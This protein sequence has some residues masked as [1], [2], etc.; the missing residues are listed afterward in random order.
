[1]P[2]GQRKKQDKATFSEPYTSHHKPI[3]WG[4]KSKQI[5]LLQK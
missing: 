4:A 5:I 1:M 2:L 3:N